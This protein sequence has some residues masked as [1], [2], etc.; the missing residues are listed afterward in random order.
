MA[1]SS[2]PAS[3]VTQE[4]LQNPVHKGYMTVAEFA[5]YLMP[6]DPASPTLVN[7]F[8]VVCAAFYE[9]GFRAPMHQFRR[10]LL[11]P[12]GL[13]LHHLTPSRI[14][15]MVVFVTLCEA[16]IGIEPPLNLWSHFFWIQ[17][18]QDLGAGAVSVG[19]V[20]VSIRSG[21]GV[22]SYFSFPQPNTL[23]G[24]PK[25]WFLLKNEADAP[26]PMFMGG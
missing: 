15:H 26:L 6:V 23:V 5:T 17:L 20:D 7:G 21:L 8:I 2:W 4:Y 24:W 14:L 18:W 22:D 11:Q 13:E 25:A 9:W 10:S 19:S 16:Y 12:Y 3:E 1:E